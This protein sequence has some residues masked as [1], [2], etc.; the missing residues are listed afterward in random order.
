MY[1]DQSPLELAKLRW[2]NM[3]CDQSSLELAKL[4]LDGSICIVINRH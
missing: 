2:I 1:G 4:M 3:Y